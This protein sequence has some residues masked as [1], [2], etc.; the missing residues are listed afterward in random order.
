M[1]PSDAVSNGFHHWTA[2][3]ALV[4]A[5]ALL[6]LGPTLLAL[7]ASVATALWAVACL[8]HPTSDG[9]EGRGWAIAALGWAVTLALTQ[10]RRGALD[11]FFR[12]DQNIL[13]R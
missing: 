9:S 8:L 2:L 5:V 1:P 13:P 3:A 11:N 6:A 4:I 7:S 12:S 10:G